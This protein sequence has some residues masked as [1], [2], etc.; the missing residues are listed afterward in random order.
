MK[1]DKQSIIASLHQ[2][3]LAK[4]EAFLNHIAARLGRERRTTPPERSVV[5]APDYWQSYALDAEERIALFLQ[6][7]KALGGN[8][9]RLANLDEAREYIDDLIQ[10]LK[11]KRI[12]REGHPQLARIVSETAGLH[13]SI[14]GEGEHAQMRKAASEADIGIAVADFAIADTGTL[15]LTS[16]P[17]RGRSLS[18]LPTIFVGIVRAEDIKTRLGEVLAVVKSWHG[19]RMPA[20][21]HFV[22]GPSRSADIE[23]ELVIGVHGPGI[24]HVLVIG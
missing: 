5:G 14:W 3:S 12:I 23:G 4:Q 2:Q 11:A 15:V 24:V 8:A 13:I 19:K 6:N 9:A 16:T 1:D 10:T 18:L 21:I 7:W 22:S 20:G 17:E